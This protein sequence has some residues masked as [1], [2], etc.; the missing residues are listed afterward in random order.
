[1]L[2]FDSLG[3]GRSVPV[4]AAVLAGGRS[5]RMGADKRF[6]RFNGEFLVDRALR[7]AR[8]ALS[9]GESHVYLCGDVPGRKALTD[10][11]AGL[12]PLSGV[13]SAI[14]AISARS[15]DRHR[16]EWLLILPV[17]MPL[18]SVSAL[19]GLLDA[20]DELESEEC[21]AIS[22]D[23]FEMP[24][25]LRCNGETERVLRE[26]CTKNP[27]EARSIR[28]LQKRLVTRRIGFDPLQRFEFTNANAPTD[29][30]AI[31]W[32]ERA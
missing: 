27:S 25:L 26:I 28:V 22:Y 6:F 7:I 17:D 23:G 12:G 30:A 29:W 2:Q 4:S 15:I 11:V 19:R 31:A 1:M 14:E 8:E 18:L 3:N 13:L 24:F 20:K 5:S 21:A 32:K 16:D 9:D 10:R